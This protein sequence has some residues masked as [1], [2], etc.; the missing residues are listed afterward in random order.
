MKLR[1]NQ[2]IIGRKLFT[3]QKRFVDWLKKYKRNKK[4]GVGIEICCVVCDKIMI[5]KKE[6]YV[7]CGILCKDDFW[8]K[9]DPRKRNSKRVSKKN[10]AINEYLYPPSPDDHW[11]TQGDDMEYNDYHNK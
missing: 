10:K 11:C 6:S 3:V 1:D 8:N 4:I 5:K 9:I 2:I 7:F